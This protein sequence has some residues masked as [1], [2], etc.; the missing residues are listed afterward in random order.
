[1][2]LREFRAELP[3]TQTEAMRRAR[4]GAADG[5]R[6]VASRQTAGQGRGAHTWVSPPGNLYLSVIVPSPLARISILSL[7]LGSRLR[8]ALSDRYG[9]L[10]VL[11]WP[12]DLL[13]PGPQGARKLIG[14]LVDVVP[15]PTLGTAAVIGVGVNVAAPP[16]AYPLELRGRVV[17]LLELV[18]TAPELAEVEELVVAAIRSALCALATPDGAAE[19][20]VA[21]RDSLYGVGRRAT[22]DSHL[23]GIIRGVGEDGELLLS[24]PS[25]ELAVHAGNL[26]LEEA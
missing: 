4:E 14:I 26:V 21:C 5:T 23:T 10:P 24:T 12:N 19:V 16:S 2:E 20:L 13:V 11:K 1:V 8:S 6:V 17:S 15:S 3:S 22:V 7:A 9:V 18:G 25:G